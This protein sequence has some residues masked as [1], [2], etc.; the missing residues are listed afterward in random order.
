VSDE[1]WF[2]RVI[3]HSVSGRED[4]FRKGVRERDGKCVISGEIN[5]LAQWNVWAGFEA[6]HVFPLEHENLWIEYNY[7]RWI[8]NMDD[9]VGSSKINST[10]NG[11]LIADNLHTR[12]GQYLFSINPDV[13]I[14]Q[15]ELVPAILM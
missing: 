2:A 13:S 6:A 15:L 3:S 5:H 12:F 1:A 11:F 10:Q 4:A 14:L 7:A 8:T 9:V